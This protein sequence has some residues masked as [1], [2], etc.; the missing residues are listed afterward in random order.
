MV[1]KLKTPSFNPLHTEQ[2]HSIGWNNGSVGGTSFSHTRYSPAPVDVDPAS[3]TSSSSFGENAALKREKKL[4]SD[5]IKHLKGIIAENDRQHRDTLERQI[6]KFN[7][8]IRSLQ[9]IND[10]LAYENDQLVHE[11]DQLVHENHHHGNRRS[12]AQQS[13][14]NY[15]HI[16]IAFMLGVLVSKIFSAP[17][18]NNSASNT[19]SSAEQIDLIVKEWNSLTHYQNEVFHGYSTDETHLRRILK[20]MED[21]LQHTSRP[22]VFLIGFQQEASAHIRPF[23]QKLIE[24]VNLNK[25]AYRIE[26]SGSETRKQLDEE[27][28]PR[29]ST[30]VVILEQI[31]KLNGNKP[32]LLQVISDKDSGPAKDAVIIATVIVEEKDIVLTGES[33]STCQSTIEKH[34][35]NR[36]LSSELPIDHLNPILSRITALTFCV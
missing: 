18:E 4:L 32:L 5:E 29:L 13:S 36:W 7:G 17:T 1:N 16:S 19:L 26:I 2:L 23:F 11:N 15:F 28:H 35:T 27:I 12:Y 9:D 14:I 25:Q 3:N 24:F 30:D 20:E 8:E 33:T 34:L 31:D 10:Q 22:R 6:A 21:F